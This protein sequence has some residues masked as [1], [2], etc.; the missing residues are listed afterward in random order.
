MP[1]ILVK[2][3]VPLLL[4]RTRR[5]LIF[6]A[7][8]YIPR[9]VICVLIAVFIYFG[10][11]LQSHPTVAYILLVVLLGLNDA[12][13][14]VQGAA[15]GGFFAQISDTRIGG[16]YYTLLASL[17]NAG[18]VVSSSLVLYT[19]SW[20]PDEWAYFIEVGV[21][22]LLGCVWLCASWRLIHRLQALP[23]ER[24]HLKIRSQT[25]DG[26]QHHQMTAMNNKQAELPAVAGTAEWFTWL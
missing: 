22:L 9:L 2:V 13:V 18:Q 21:C 15:R 19:A 20:L 3:T 12:L 6:F 17:N 7:R 10:P 24:W 8:S 4:S 11:R 23:A 16:T 1:L 26:D 5:P 25:V 14:Y